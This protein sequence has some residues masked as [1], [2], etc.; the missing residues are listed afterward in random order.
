[1]S[2]LTQVVSTANLFYIYQTQAL[3]RCHV[4]SLPISMAANK[5]D[6]D[7]ARLQHLAYF[8]TVGCATV[9]SEPTQLHFSQC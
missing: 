3:H 7:L 4:L 1:M 5:F 2:R 9:V 6:V 8:G